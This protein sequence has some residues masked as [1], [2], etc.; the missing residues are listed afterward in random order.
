MYEIPKANDQSHVNRLMGKSRNI[1][2][3]Q[4]YIREIFLTRDST[5]APNALAK[6]SPRQRKKRT[7]THLSRIL[8]PIFSLLPQ[9]S[10]MK[11]RALRGGITRSPRIRRKFVIG[12]LNKSALC[13]YT[14]SAYARELIIRR[15]S[16]RNIKSEI[17]IFF[18]PWLIIN[19]RVRYE[20][21]ADEQCRRLPVEWIGSFCFCGER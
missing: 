21:D 7:Y 2:R 1:K 14:N 16:S 13:V 8:H 5:G 9:R 17:S 15:T 19:R 18:H 20:R 4:N 3:I 10:W 6:S 11:Y 12:W